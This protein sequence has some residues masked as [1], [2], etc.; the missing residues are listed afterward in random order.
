MSTNPMRRIVYRKCQVCAY[1]YTQP[2]LHGACPSCHSE[3]VI[4]TDVGACV[5]PYRG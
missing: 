3:D 1:E 5:A 4:I 2:A